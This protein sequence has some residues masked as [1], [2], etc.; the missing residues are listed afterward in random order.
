LTLIRH[1]PLRVSAWFKTSDPSP[2]FSRKAGRIIRKVEVVVGPA[3]P[4]IYGHFYLKETK[5]KNLVLSCGSRENEL[6]PLSWK[7]GD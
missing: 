5:S 6:G 7:P 1:C 2:I 4:G 3:D